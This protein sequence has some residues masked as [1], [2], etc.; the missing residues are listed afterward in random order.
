MTEP[1]TPPPPSLAASGAWPFEAF[2]VAMRTG[3]TIDGRQ[4]QPIMPT[5][6]FMYMADDELMA[7]QLL[8]KSTFSDAL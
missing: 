2:A 4:L 6:A 1:G 3:K 5:S 8:I 7:I